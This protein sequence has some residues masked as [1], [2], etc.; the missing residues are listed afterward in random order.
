MPQQPQVTAADHQHRQE[1]ASSS[2]GAANPDGRLENPSEQELA[3]RMAN[4]ADLKITGIVAD[5]RHHNDRSGAPRRERSR[6]R[7]VDEWYNSSIRSQPQWQQSSWDTSYQRHPPA[8]WSGHSKNPVGHGRS[9]ST[10]GRHSRDMYS[11]APALEPWVDMV[12]VHKAPNP[13]VPV[14]NYVV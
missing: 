12:L 1:E 7:A 10:G 9:L 14:I 5:P 13:D 8:Q 3:D 4:F 6:G 2:S 11:L